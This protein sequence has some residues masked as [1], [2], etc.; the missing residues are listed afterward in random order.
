MVGHE[1]K[2]IRRGQS[3]PSRENSLRKAL[4]TVNTGCGYELLVAFVWVKGKI[5]WGR[6]WRPPQH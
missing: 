5:A 6:L 1:K 2:R 4:E 3:I